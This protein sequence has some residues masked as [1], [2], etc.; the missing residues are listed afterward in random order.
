MTQFL[1]EL[2]ENK[3]LYES[4]MLCE[5]VETLLG[6]LYAQLTN[7]NFKNFD[8]LR[9]DLERTS[10]MLAGL[11]VLGKKDYRQHFPDINN[12]FTLLKLLNDLDEPHQEKEFQSDI[13]KTVKI[14]ADE[15]VLSLGEVAA[16]VAKEFKDLLDAANEH[17]ENEKTMNEIKN[18]IGKMRTFFGQVRNTLKHQLAA[19]QK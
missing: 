17:P 6:K 7:L 8:D 19:N 15:K 2:S 5:N 4:L 10:T 1:A 16:K 11:V 9:V 12:N 14:T 3:P 13:Q 18:K